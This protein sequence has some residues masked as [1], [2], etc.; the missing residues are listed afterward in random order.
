M[1]RLLFARLRN[2]LLRAR[3]RK[4][5]LNP[6][7]RKNLTAL[8]HLNRK[9]NALKLRCVV[10]DMETTGLDLTS[11]R[12]VSM[13]AMRIVNG[14]IPFGDI[15]TSLVSP[16]RDIPPSAVKIHGIVPSMVADAPHFTQV[17]D[18]FLHFLGTDVLAGFQ[19][20]FDLHFLN[21][22][23]RRTYGFRLQNL[24]LDVQLMCR[25]TLFSAHLGSYAV[26]FKDNPDLDTMAKHFGIEIYERHTATGD[27]L[28]TAMILQRILS[29]AEK[30]GK[31]Q[32][33]NFIYSAIG[34]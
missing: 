22:F 7:A 25:K 31:G 33:R 16:G 28:A 24:V 18:R 29:E 26:R 23:M 9:Q 30:T 11:D 17:F 21:Q 6:V 13:A 4:K 10:L 34:I 3:L 15:F 12:V 19:I 8:N 2:R 5:S 27:A 1:W 14:R 32:L 20:G